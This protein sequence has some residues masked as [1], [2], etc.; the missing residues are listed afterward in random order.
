MNTVLKN[1]C[2][3][4]AI[5]ALVIG[6]NGTAIGQGKLGRVREAVRETKPRKPKTQAPKPRDESERSEQEHDDR[7]DHQSHRGHNRRQQNRSSHRTHDRR[8]RSPNILLG[9]ATF[10]RPEP[11]HVVH[12]HLAPAA[13]APVIITAPQPTYETVVEPTAQIHPPTTPQ[14][15]PVETYFNHSPDF[16]WAVRLSALGGTDFA[17]IAHGSFGLLIQPRGAL[18]ID[19]SVTMFRESG[20]SVRDHLYLGDVNLTF[21]PT[22]A[23]DRFRMRIGAGIN[24][25]GDSHGGDAGFNMT[26]GMDWKLTERWLMTGEIDF[27]T[28]GDTDLTHAQVSLGRA[29]SEQ[30]ELTFGYNYHDI[31]GVTMGSAFTGLR[32]RF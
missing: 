1:A 24:W 13:T 15:T 25:L 20:M 2:L 28:I 9:A 4:L 32:F 7:D 30:T 5:F 21:E 26:G 23:S 18:G 14:P 10:I 31:G 19:T 12:H 16:D 3:A 8:D 6:A 27:G 11:V 22:L 17:D 29:L